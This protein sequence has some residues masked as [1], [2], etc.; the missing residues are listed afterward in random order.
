ME[1]GVVDLRVKRK[2]NGGDR[3]TGGGRE[4]VKGETGFGCTY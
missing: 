4:E 2:I 1:Q 3:T